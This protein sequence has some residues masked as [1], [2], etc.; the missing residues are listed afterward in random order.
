MAIDAGS[1]GACN[2]LSIIIVIVI[3]IVIHLSW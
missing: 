1:I 3:V 2:L